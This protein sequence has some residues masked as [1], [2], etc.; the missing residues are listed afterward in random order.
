MT[1]IRKHTEYVLK[2]NNVTDICD[3]DFSY[4]NGNQPAEAAEAGVID[5]AK[6]QLEL[7]EVIKAYTFGYDDSL[8]KQHARYGGDRVNYL[9]LYVI[10]RR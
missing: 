10:T 5:L 8:K 7:E 4:G 6:Y 3:I 1:E 9:D 2:K